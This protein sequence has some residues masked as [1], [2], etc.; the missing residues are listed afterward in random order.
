MKRPLSINSSQLVAISLTLS[1][2]SVTWSLAQR[3]PVESAQATPVINNRQTKQ[4]SSRQSRQCTNGEPK[5]TATFREGAGIQI[6]L[7]PTVPGF[8]SQ[9]YLL[10]INN[11]SLRGL[12]QEQIGKLLTGKNKLHLISD[13]GEEISIYTSPF[14]Q[15]SPDRDSDQEAY[16]IN[17]TTRFNGD[18]SIFDKGLGI[19]N[20]NYDELSSN[21]LMAEAEVNQLINL[22]EYDTENCNVS[23]SA[24]LTYCIST[25]LTMGMIP[26]AKRNLHRLIELLNKQ[27]KNDTLFNSK[28]REVYEKAFAFGLYKE[29]NDLGSTVC[30][31]II[32][33]SSTQSQKE[34]NKEDE[35]LLF[36]RS[37][38]DNLAKTSPKDALKLLEDCSNIARRTPQSMLWQGS[39]NWNAEFY[40]TCGDYERA[41]QEYEKALKQFT[42]ASFAR[43]PQTYT[44]QQISA[45]SRYNL[46]LLRLSELAL[47]SNQVD[48][49]IKYLEQS[50]GSYLASF[51]P[52]ILAKLEE[53]PLMCPTPKLVT[54]A[55]IDS[56]L[57]KGDADSKS[58][59][60]KLLGET[61]ADK[62]GK[63]AGTSKDLTTIQN[64]NWRK[65]FYVP[66]THSINRETFA[67]ELNEL[68]EKL[69]VLSTASGTKDKSYKSLKSSIESLFK[70]SQDTNFAYNNG[71]K[72]I[73]RYTCLFYL[74]KELAASG[75][76][77][78]S[79]ALFEKLKESA[80]SLK[81]SP[82]N[83]LL[84]ELELAAITGNFSKLDTLLKPVSHWTELTPM[85]GLA[86]IY[87]ATGETEKAERFLERAEKQLQEQEAL[88]TLSED[89][90]TQI[91]TEAQLVKPLIALDRCKIAALNNDISN[92]MN[93]FRKSMFEIDAIRLTAPSSLLDSFNHKYL[94]RIIEIINITNSKGHRDKAIEISNLT[95]EKLNDKSCWLGVFQNSETSINLLRPQASL[96]ANLGKFLFE[97]GDHEKALPYL[98][99]ASSELKDWTPRQVLLTLAK[100]AYV[101]GDYAAASQAYSNLAKNSQYSQDISSPSWLPQLRKS[102]AREAIESALRAKE[103]PAG[104]LCNLY[105]DLADMLT[106]QNEAK[107]RT[108]LYKKALALSDPY[109]ET[110]KDL[111]LKLARVESTSG[112]PNGRLDMLAWASRAATKKNS[113]DAP[114]LQMN[115]ANEEIRLGQFDNSVKNYLEAIKLTKRKDDNHNYCDK[116][117]SSLEWWS[118]AKLSKAGRSSAVDTIC[119]ALL[120]R[121]KALYGDKSAETKEVLSLLIPFYAT[122]GDLIKASNYL[123]SYLEIDP[124]KIELG[125]YNQHAPSGSLEQTLVSLANKANTAE[126]SKSA[127]NKLLA[128]AKI[129]YGADDVHVAR[130][131]VSQ[132]KIEFDGGHLE[133]AEFLAKEAQKIEEL[134]DVMNSFDIGYNVSKSILFEI[135]SKQGNKAKLAALD[136]YYK[137]RIKESKKHSSLAPG[138]T[139]KQKQDYLNYWHQRSPYRLMTIALQYQMLNEA[140]RAKNWQQIKQEAPW[141]LRTLAHNSLFLSGGCTPSPSPATQKYFGYKTL[142][143][144]CLN[145]D[146][147]SGALNLLK[148]ANAEKCYN[149][150]VEELVFLAKIECLCGNKNKTRELCQQ[151]RKE[152]AARKLPR[153]S[154]YSYEIAELMK[155][156]GSEQEQKQTTEHQELLMYQNLVETY[157]QYAKSKQ[158]ETQSNLVLKK[159]PIRQPGPID[160]IIPATPVSFPQ[161]VKQGE[162]KYSLN[163][164]ILCENLVLENGAL[165]TRNTQPA[166]MLEY[167]FAGA[168][169]SLKANQ[170]IHKAGSFQFLFDGGNLIAPQATP[171]PNIPWSGGTGAGAS[172]GVLFSGTA[173]GGYMGG[174]GYSS[175]PAVMPLPLKPALEAP[176]N[177]QRLDSN[178]EELVP[179]EGDYIADSL[180]LTSLIILKAR[181]IRIFISPKSTAPIVLRTAI[182]ASI[183][184]EPNWFKANRAGLLEFWYN[185]SGEINLGDYTAFAGIIYAPKAKVILG[186]NCQFTGAM[187]AKDVIVGENSVI[188]YAASLAQWQAM[189]K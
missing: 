40:A 130:I 32:G 164:A 30:K 189:L 25:Q 78:E 111:S 15:P 113:P 185:G 63:E 98:K 145:T 172:T 171:T 166:G 82:Y 138:T 2:G 71:Q 51:K 58:K 151:A 66:S 125:T 46:I 102:Y 100:C 53:L 179:E 88:T 144:A 182:G 47:Q 11:T 39:P 165:V 4:I 173:G 124:R 139:N 106:A 175:P 161:E 56:Y 160:A 64:G 135:Y 28:L 21:T 38:A 95:I 128:S 19:G 81:N 133:K 141:F 54:Y 132:A 45:L 110:A 91:A 96:K 137:E 62:A 123:Q 70:Q 104:E 117:F 61:Q 23:L 120:D 162:D 50:R 174:L 65:E 83:K 143:E 112:D 13:L 183:N 5:F 92:L 48:K 73:N 85:R 105:K 44:A 29:A 177:A 41:S 122:K 68:Y 146:D 76:K 7:M 118:L 20:L 24:A 150:S 168:F 181:K 134:Y 9:A 129:Y 90:R 163:Y 140:Y 149:S 126:F 59:A 136:E 121:A 188:N 154:N 142:I 169:R 37:F 155:M 10:N 3:F 27:P 43:G 184:A 33:S 74:A 147:R 80:L 119:L 178:L 156:A 22:A 99:A 6:N 148:Q 17:F 114:Q 35:E 187:V 101:R 87:I 159:P 26:A 60:E 89:Q 42:G 77:D 49:S 176:A 57:R 67:I 79:I 36:V 93:Q 18:S 186:K 34:T 52:D 8:D 152:A 108:E 131:L 75:Y 12:S 167:S 153:Y 31:G 55:L 109:S 94:N 14:E 103:L 157:R 115:L 127:L 84:I 170:P 180:D 1:I 16:L 158:R 116:I 86:D 107:E 72:Q 97:A 69:E